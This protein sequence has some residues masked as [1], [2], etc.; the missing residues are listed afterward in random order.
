MERRSPG[1]VDFGLDDEDVLLSSEENYPGRSDENHDH[2]RR[3][4]LP[5]SHMDKNRSSRG[6]SQ[7]QFG[8]INDIIDQRLDKANRDSLSSKTVMGSNSPVRHGSF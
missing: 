6:L 1:Q 8:V 3:F 2:I 4:A 5:Q 7:F